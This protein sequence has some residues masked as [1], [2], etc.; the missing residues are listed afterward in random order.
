LRNRTG[1]DML[2][3]M[4]TYDE[5][6]VHDALPRVLEMVTDVPTLDGWLKE[7]G[8]SK[9]FLFATAFNME[10]QGVNPSTIFIVATMVAWEVAKT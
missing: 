8:I 9:E 1:Y 10:E 7:Q 6:T 5:N 3:G 2:V 4:D